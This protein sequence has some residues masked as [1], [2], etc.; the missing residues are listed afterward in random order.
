MVKWFSWVLP[1]ADKN[2]LKHHYSFNRSV[3]SHCGLRPTSFEDSGK[4]LIDFTGSSSGPV[5]LQT[6]DPGPDSDQGIPQFRHSGF[7]LT[8]IQGAAD[9]LIS[10]RS[11]RTWLFG[12][13]CKNCLIKHPL[14]SDA[15]GSLWHNT[16]S[17]CRKTR[18]FLS[19]K[20]LLFFYSSALPRWLT[21]HN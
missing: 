14:T 10:G 19:L 18:F 12:H 21:L 4:A 8:R 15:R 9:L 13:P 16:D 2:L 6:R 17:S 3:Q 20:V 11:R 1:W 5:W 7:S